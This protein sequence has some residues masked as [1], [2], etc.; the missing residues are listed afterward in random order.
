MRDLIERL[1]RADG[2]SRELDYAILREID[3]RAQRSGPVYS[4]PRY[5]GSIDAAMTLL[6]ADHKHWN[7]GGS[8]TQG[9]AGLGLYGACVNDNTYGESRYPALALC[10]AALRAKE[11]DNG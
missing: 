6:P 7:V 1:E 5:T 10:I 2:P 9:F 11:A 8:P 4:D 3:P